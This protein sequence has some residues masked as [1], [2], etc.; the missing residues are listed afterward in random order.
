MITN[1]DYKKAK[2]KL[3]ILLDL[4]KSFGKKMSINICKHFKKK[5][6]TQLVVNYYNEEVFVKLSKEEVIELRDKLDE[7]INNK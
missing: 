3:I 5:S 7:W 6:N 4:K 1:K 2:T